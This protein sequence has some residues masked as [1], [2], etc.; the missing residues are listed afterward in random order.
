MHATAGVFAAFESEHKMAGGA[1]GMFHDLLVTEHHYIFLE[2][3][4]RMNWWTL[5]AKHTFGRA[6][7]V[8]CLQFDRNKPVK[9]RAF[10]P[11][12]SCI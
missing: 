4:M 3:S 2:N 8:E 7:I 10:C 9:V 5:F 11:D 12:Q 1:F 6:A